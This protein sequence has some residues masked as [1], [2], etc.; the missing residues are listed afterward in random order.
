MIVTLTT[1]GLCGLI[2]MVLSLR[3]STV[4]RKTK[5]SLGDGGDALLLCR[6]R[7]HAN[8]AEYVPIILILL[9]L[10]E[11]QRGAGP[12]LWGFGILLVAARILQA[13]GVELPAPNLPRIA[14]TLGSVVALVSLS[15]W[16]LAI[17]ASY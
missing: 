13:I 8:F 1:A 5:I 7:A 4:R 2:Y 16:S 9:G 15:I 14:G 10:V 3:V 17:A 12:L 6:I 11:S